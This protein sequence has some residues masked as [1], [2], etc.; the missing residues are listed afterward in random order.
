[1]TMQNLT[2]FIS[3]AAGIIL[4]LSAFAA[5]II[6]GN[7]INS[8]VASVKQDYANDSVYSEA[9][10]EVSDESIVAREELMATLMRSPQGNVIVRDDVSKY[11]LTI[12]AGAGMNTILTVRKEGMLASE[13]ESK[14]IQFGK[15]RWDLDKIELDLYLQAQTYK[16][17][18]ITFSNGEIKTVLFYGE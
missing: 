2:E 10:L 17:K 15:D 1:M 12:T 8:S 11:V 4:F 5:A 13:E 16:V 18:N 7:V 6:C 3:R 9:S 14:T